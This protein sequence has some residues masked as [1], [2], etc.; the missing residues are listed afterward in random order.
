MSDWIYP[1]KIGG[2]ASEDTFLLLEDGNFLLLETGGKIV[3]T[4]GGGGDETVWDYPT[5]N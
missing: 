3:L 5:K 1:D 2:G 4:E